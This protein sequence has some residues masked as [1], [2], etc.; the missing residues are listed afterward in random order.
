MGGRQEDPLGEDMQH[1]EVRAPAQ[2]LQAPADHPVHAVP[3]D[4]R[5]ARAHRRRRGIVV[6]RG[7]LDLERRVEP[8]GEHVDGR[9][10]AREAPEPAL[11]IV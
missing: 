2:V 8:V 6:D 5:L 11:V 1:P 3:R 4:R 7:E 9:E 10:H